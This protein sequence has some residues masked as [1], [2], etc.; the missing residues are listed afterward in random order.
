MSGALSVGWGGGL[1]WNI[2]NIVV[3]K[4]EPR[5]P[6]YREFKAIASKSS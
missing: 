3:L 5:L 6:P 2:N 4:V 1:R